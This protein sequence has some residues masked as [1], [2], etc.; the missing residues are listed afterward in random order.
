MTFTLEELE[1]LENL[2]Y[3]ISSNN[4]LTLA[5]EIKVLRKNR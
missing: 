2:G 5:R 3:T 4:K 1:E